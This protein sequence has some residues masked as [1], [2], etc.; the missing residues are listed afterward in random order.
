MEGGRWCV[1]SVGVGED[2]EGRYRLGLARLCPKL[3]HIINIKR[4]ILC[5]VVNFIS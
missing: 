2:T 5:V 4:L 1:E 3:F